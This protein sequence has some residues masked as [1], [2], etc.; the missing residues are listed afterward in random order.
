MEFGARAQGNRSII[1][2]PAK[3][4]TVQR[5]NDKIKNRDFWMPFAP[6]ILEEKKA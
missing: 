1:A 5:L 2:D 6:S 4:D 3:I